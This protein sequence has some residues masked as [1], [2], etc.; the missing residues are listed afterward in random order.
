MI[1]KGSGWCTKHHKEVL[2]KCL[3]NPL[4]S[5]EAC[6]SC[7][8]FFSKEKYATVEELA[9]TYQKNPGSVRKLLI[10]MEERGLIRTYYDKFE[11][12]RPFVPKRR[13]IYKFIPR[14]YI[15][16]LEPSLKRKYRRRLSPEDLWLRRAWRNSHT[17][18]T[19]EEFKKIYL[20]LVDA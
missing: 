2:D 8:F 1:I 19:F 4:L 7:P 6:S 9:Q 18:L 15:P 12:K 10:T 13:I 5:S 16:V 11:D 14:E 20:K 17:N 3:C